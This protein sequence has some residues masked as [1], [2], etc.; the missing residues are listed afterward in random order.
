MLSA[1]VAA[2]HELALT[3]PHW[4]ECPRPIA[5]RLA[6]TFRDALAGYCGRRVIPASKRWPL[7]AAPRKASQPRPYVAKAWRAPR[8]EALAANPIACASCGEPVVKRRRRYCEACLTQVRR[9]R[10]PR[11]IEAARKALA[12]QAAAGKDPSASAQAG[13]KR[14]EANA[15]HH[16]RNH[17]WAPEHPG[18]REEAWFKREIAPKLDTFTLKEMGK[19][20]GLSL[21]ACSRIRTGAKI[22]HPRHWNRL[23]ALIK[24]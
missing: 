19:A 2:L 5:A 16:L 23:L 1:S 12:A 15:E 17:R 18:Q 21:A 13:R 22:P 7:V 3:L 14:G 4:R 11:A 20:T 24:D 9:E 8:P 10:G 6:Q